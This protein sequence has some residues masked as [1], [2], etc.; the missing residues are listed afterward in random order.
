MSMH[1]PP[2]RELLDLLRERRFAIG[3][4]HHIRIGRVVGCDAA[5]TPE[6]LR[7]AVAS[8]V[9]TAPEQRDAFDECWKDWMRGVEQRRPPDVVVAPPQPPKP[10]RARR[11]VAI[12]AAVVLIGLVAVAVSWPRE[13]AERP[14]DVRV[15]TPGSGS[16]IEDA[17]PTLP[18][19]TAPVSYPPPARP[20]PPSRS[21]IDAAVVA[22][23]LGAVVLALAA[24]AAVLG[25]R[26]RRRF[27][28][29]PWR[30]A[31]AVPPATAPTLTAVAIDDAAADLTRRVHH[32]GAELDPVRSADATAARGG[33]PTLVYHRPRVVPRYVVLQ[34]IGGGADRWRFLYDDLLRGLARLGIQIE[35]FTFAASPS[36]CLGTDGRI[37]ALD[38][39]LD[40]ADALIAIGDGDAA[41]DPLTGERARWLTSLR[42]A[43]VR[44]WINPL[45]PARWGIGA[46][47][48]AADTP[49]EH[50]VA[51]ALGVMHGG[52]IRR[53]PERAY[54]AVIER[55]PG[56][57]SA[58]AALHMAIG[59]RAFRLI[60]AVAALGPPTVAAARWIA[61][62]HALELDEHDWLAVATL[63]WFRIGQWPAGVRERLRE[64]IARDA[65]GLARALDGSA[66]RL[67]A[68][69]EP[70]RGTGAHLA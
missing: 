2:L 1:A 12:A 7:V 27:V 43:P 49:M 29:G 10:P 3:V 17:P 22:C 65:P 39:V 26:A 28:P 47:A 4:D 35:R 58:I 68:A 66:D 38:D 46:R 64:W 5:W 62:A 23:V 67:V 21:A 14:M 40:H 60:A 32:T 36:Q 11:R 20:L 6:T 59:E 48:I 53:T 61:E 55:A 69:S 25:A 8:L 18:P 24:I 13:R 15:E 34:D 57:A 70:P 37:V 31:L 42:H 63:P 30:Y 44:L 41:V 51:Q 9:V 54:P 33:W 52:I 50:G 56:T 16:G 45:P 19:F